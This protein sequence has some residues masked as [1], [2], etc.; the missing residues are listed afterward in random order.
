MET[1]S[2]RGP[3]TSML[4]VW[5]RFCGTG[6]HCNRPQ[7]HPCVKY[8]SWFPADNVSVALGYDA[9]VK[10]A[11]A[12]A[13]NDSTVNGRSVR[14][15]ATWFQKGNHVRTEGT[16]HLDGRSSLWGS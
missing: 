5:W 11:F 2:V 4:A 9:G 6:A 8:V 3:K 7:P 14:A 10:S 16:V 15:S 1:N 12:T 13:T